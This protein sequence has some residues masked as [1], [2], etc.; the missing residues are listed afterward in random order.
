MDANERRGQEPVRTA[1]GA[2]RAR[3]IQV[4]IAD[5][6]PILRRAL[7]TWLDAQPGL[8]V[9]GEASSGREA[10][11][12]V[13][14]HAI[15]VLLL[16]VDMP[17]Q[18][19]IDALAMIRAKSKRPDLGVLVFSGYPENLYALP[20]LR[21]G[22]R[23]YL[24]KCCAP[25]E[26]AAAVRHVAAG[27]RWITPAV[28]QLLADEATAPPG[29][30]GAHQRLSPRELQV[31][32][33]LARGQSTTQ[34]ASE[35]SLSPKTVSSLRSGLLRKLDVRSAGQLAYYAVKNRLVA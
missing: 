19:G 29:Q 15:D 8:H 12:L 11:D 17:G 3:A 4:G 14:T 21:H 2:F 13:R 23:G 28:A 22:A 7:R 33:K 26:I 30:D 10:I 1:A 34:A 5:D 24:E 16:D 9:A 31:L 25:A 27:R 6:H 18:S 20:L 35:L 32:L